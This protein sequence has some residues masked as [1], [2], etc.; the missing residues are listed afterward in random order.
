MGEACIFLGAYR[1]R[2]IAINPGWLKEVR[3]NWPG[4]EPV[5]EL[6]AMREGDSEKTNLTGEKQRRQNSDARKR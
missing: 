2:E 3:G 5:E 6:L 1:P 4:D